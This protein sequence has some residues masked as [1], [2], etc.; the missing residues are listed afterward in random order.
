M[1]LTN[2]GK[3]IRELP[4]PSLFSSDKFEG[5]LL[6]LI[7]FGLNELPAGDYSVEAVVK[8]NRRNTTALQAAAF[9]VL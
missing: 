8:D 7:Q 4:A 6:C 2:G 3:V 1:S 9:R 5:K